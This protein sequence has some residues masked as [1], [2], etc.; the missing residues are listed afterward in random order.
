MRHFTPKDRLLVL[1]GQTVRRAVFIRN[2]LITLLTALLSGVGMDVM[3]QSNFYD[4]VN[5]KVMHHPTLAEP[6]IEFNL[7]W[8]DD[9]NS[10]KNDSYYLQ[11]ASGNKDYDQYN[12]GRGPHFF[13]DGHYIASFPD[14]LGF[15]WNRMVNAC[16]TYD[17]PW[18]RTSKT[19]NG[20][21]YEIMLWNPR[22][23]S[24]G[25]YWVTVIVTLDK[26]AANTSHNVKVYSRW[27]NVGKG[28][29]NHSEIVS[30]T[31][32]FNGT[33]L[34]TK[35]TPRGFMIT[36]TDGKIETNYVYGTETAFASEAN[37]VNLGT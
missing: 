33:G 36:D 34:L 2:V 32:N 29:A 22:R 20:V 21:K 3:A 15:D 16:N 26:I 35:R 7:L 14:H 31:W 1:T 37:P 28:G 4:D 23:D 27:R 24:S 19:F 8:Y 6:W 10:S 18:T 13:V 30:K 9:P 12:S 11:Q 25:K 17:G 5:T